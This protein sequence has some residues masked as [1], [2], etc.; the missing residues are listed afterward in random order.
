MTAQT[1]VTPVPGDPRSL[2]ARVCTHSCTQAKEPHRLTFLKEIIKQQCVHNRYQVDTLKFKSLLIHE[3]IGFF[4]FKV[5][6]QINEFVW[7]ETS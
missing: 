1:T 3:R 6:S 5:A 2:P 7:S 4:S